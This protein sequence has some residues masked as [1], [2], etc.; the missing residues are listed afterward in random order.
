[1]SSGCLY[2]TQQ[3]LIHLHI[4]SQEA[5]SAPSIV[6]VTNPYSQT[7]VE[8]EVIPPLPVVTSERLPSLEWRTSFLTRFRN[9]RESLS[10]KSAPD[11]AGIPSSDNSKKWRSFLRMTEESGQGNGQARLPKGSLLCHFQTVSYPHMPLQ[12]TTE[13]LCG[14]YRIRSYCCWNSLGRQSS[15]RQKRMQRHLTHFLHSGYLLFL[16]TW[17][18]VWSA[19]T[20]AVFVLWPAPV[21]LRSVNIARCQSSTTSSR[22]W[23][24]G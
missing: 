16:L 5:L 23:V 20:S 22:S 10:N 2:A 11:G 17:T 8:Q 7:Y 13:F 24:T 18:S 19:T 9:M 3:V 4:Q 15:R 12:C 6:R 21:F 14:F 1:M